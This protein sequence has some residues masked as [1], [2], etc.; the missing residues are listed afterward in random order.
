MI[1][2]L[3]NVLYWLG[4][5]IA[6]LIAILAVYAYIMEGH[7]KSDGLGLTVA[8]F[9]AALVAWIFGWACRYILAGR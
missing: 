1:G 8:F 6:G 4:C 3:G 2:R 5:I 9:V 7:S